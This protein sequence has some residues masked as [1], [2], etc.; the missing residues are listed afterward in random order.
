MALAVATTSMQP[1]T[2]MQIDKML[3]K[4]QIFE[5]PEN[6][7]ISKKSSILKLIFHPEMD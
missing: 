7:A 5:L 4:I 3:L 2:A 6:F 1:M